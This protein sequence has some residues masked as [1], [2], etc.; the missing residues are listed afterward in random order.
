MFTYSPSFINQW[1]P[2]DMRVPD[3]AIERRIKYFSYTANF[4]PA[5]ANTSTSAVVTIQADSFFLWLQQNRIISDVANTTIFAT[6]PLLIA[7]TQSGTGS[8]FTDSPQHLDA[9]FGDGQNPGI[10]PVPI[11]LYPASTMQL[12]L[13]NL[14]PATAFNVRVSLIGVK[15]FASG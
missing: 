9:M 4:L 6:A 8:Q 2:P 13:G 5:A 7:L 10:P 14:S 3:G 11:L 15:I 12:T 1:L